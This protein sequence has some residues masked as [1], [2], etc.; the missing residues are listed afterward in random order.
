[1]EVNGMEQNVNEQSQSKADEQ[2]TLSPLI[3]DL[4]MKEEKM[5]HLDRQIKEN[6]KQMHHIEQS[7]TWKVSKLF[8]VFTD[9]FAKLFRREQLQK[10]QQQIVQL[11]TQLAQTEKELLQ[12]KEQVHDLRLQDTE[13]NRHE[14]Y[15]YMRD[16]KNEG[17]LVRYLD[18]FIDK[19]KTQ[20][21]NYKEALTYAARIYMNEEVEIV[22][23]HV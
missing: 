6:K 11:E 14:I 1:M 15:Q 10:Q 12:T 16:L 23:A 22:R 19:K 9:F 21:A 8:R 7:N 17:E 13:I 5:A 20:Q 3:E 4:L 18:S 2:E